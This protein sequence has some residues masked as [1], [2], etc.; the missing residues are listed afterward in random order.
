MGGR[1]DNQIIG[2]CRFSYVGLGGFRAQRRGPEEAAEIL[3]APERMHRRFAYFQNICLPSLAAQTDMDF[4]LV[5]LIGDMMPLRYRRRLKALVERYPFMHICALHPSGPL[6]ASRWAFRRGWDEKAKFVTGFRLDD[7]DAVA[8]DYI[9]K[10]RAVAD[11]L[12]D[13]GWA[14]E[15]TPAAI[16]FH[17]GIYWNMN[18]ETEPFWEFRE[19]QPLGLASAMVTPMDDKANIFRWNH[20]FLASQVRCWT[21]PNEIMF[22]RTLHGHNDSRRSIP[23]EAVPM[24]WKTARDLLRDRFGLAPRRAFSMV[25]RIRGLDAQ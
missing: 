22:V 12:L 11:Q 18:S 13:I 7:D 9:E 19:N 24:R 4:R 3:Y 2:V 17:R 1:D 21:D 10:T 5:V 8:I 25:E 20:R 16:C 6:H 23:P 15:E 14:T